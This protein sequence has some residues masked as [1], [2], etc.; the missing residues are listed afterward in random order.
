MIAVADTFDAMTS[1][2]P[3]RD[4]RT[5]EAAAG[6]I[7][8]GAGIQFCPRVVAAFRRLVERGGFTVEA[9]ESLRRSLFG[10]GEEV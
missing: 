4:A 6:E 1:E 7:Q 8:Q 5:P 2:R 10:D 3:Y 9:G